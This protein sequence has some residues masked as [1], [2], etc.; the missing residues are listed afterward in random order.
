MEYIDRGIV[1]VKPKQ[2]YVDWA[3]QL[4]DPPAQPETIV[5]LSRDCNVFLVPELVNDDEVLA[6]L[7]QFKPQ[8][9]EKELADYHD[10][11]SAWPPIRDSHTFDKWFELE[12]HS[13]VIDTVN[14]PIYT[15]PYEE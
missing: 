12:I 7:E 2:P 10:D 8:I 9:F 6:Y 13:V 4:P 1:I 14:A 3:N 11:R 5:T 15:E